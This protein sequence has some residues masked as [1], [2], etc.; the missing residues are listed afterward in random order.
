MSHKQRLMLQQPSFP[1]RVTVGPDISREVSDTCWASDVTFW[2]VVTSSLFEMRTVW[3]SHQKGWVFLWEVNLG[4]STEE[5]KKNLITSTFCLLPAH[6][7][8]KRSSK[9]K[10]K[11]G[12]LLAAKRWLCYI[13]FN[14][15]C[16]TSSK[17]PNLNT[18]E[19]SGKGFQEGFVS[20]GPKLPAPTVWYLC[21]RM[22]SW[23]V[24]HSSTS[25]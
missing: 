7:S 24:G 6:I 23:A 14:K 5:K 9:E 20:C 1:H 11:C 22:Y 16:R 4:T 17:L 3:C 10:K 2:R 18:A 15:A 19:V 21:G 25:G 8:C 12:C 13:N